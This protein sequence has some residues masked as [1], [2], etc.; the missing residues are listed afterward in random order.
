MRVGTRGRLSDAKR[1]GT[2][3]EVTVGLGHRLPRDGVHPVADG[4]Q[5]HL[6]LERVTGDDH[7][8]AGVDAHP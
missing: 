8:G 7:R 1:V 5:R 6:E 2:G 3:G 4:L